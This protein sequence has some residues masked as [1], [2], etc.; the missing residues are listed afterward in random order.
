M[1]KHCPDASTSIV[2]D[3][4]LLRVRPP[5]FEHARFLEQLEAFFPKAVK[6]GRIEFVVGKC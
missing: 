6:D 4:L 5:D 1:S 2:I 3:I